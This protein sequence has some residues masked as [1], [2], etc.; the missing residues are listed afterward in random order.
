MRCG[1]RGVAIGAS[2]VCLRLT[3]LASTLGTSYCN[4]S[5]TVIELAYALVELQRDLNQLRLLFPC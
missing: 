3:L 1:Y 5:L 4:A 2:L